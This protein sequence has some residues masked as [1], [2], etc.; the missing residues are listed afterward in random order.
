MRTLALLLILVDIAASQPH[1]WLSVLMASI[2]R[3]I[4]R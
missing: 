1:H 2:A 4:G 3:C